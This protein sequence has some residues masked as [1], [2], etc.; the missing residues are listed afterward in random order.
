MVRHRLSKSALKWWDDWWDGRLIPSDS[1]IAMLTALK[2]KHAKPGKHVD[3]HGLHLLV[4]PSGGKFWL[5]RVQHRGQRR[6]FGLGCADDVSLEEARLAAQ[7]LRRQVKRGETPQVQVV[8]PPLEPRKKVPSFEKVTRDCYDALKD[9]WNDKRKRNWLAGFEQNI[10][11]AIGSKP[12]DKVDVAV[13]RDALAPVWLKIPDTARRILQRTQAVLDF[14]FL[15]GWIPAE[16]SLRTVR[17]GL[18]KHTDRSNHYAAMPYDDAAALAQKLAAAESSVG[19]DALRF[20]IL[21]ASRSGETRGATWT[22]IDLQKKVWSIPA[23]RMKAREP[24]QVPLTPQAMNILERR[25]KLR[26]DSSEYVF[27]N[28]GKKPLTDMAVSKALKGAGV[29]GFTVHGFRSTFTDWAAEK[30]DFPKEVADKALAH[31]I[32]DPVEAAYRRTDFFEKRRSLMT[33]WADFLDGGAASP[34]NDAEAGELVAVRA[35]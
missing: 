16:V 29:D 3:H 31:K 25:L 23:E 17:K 14:A 27:T 22:E 4:R 15:N 26:T 24:H 20:L 28:D 11:D 6:E 5:V 9:G 13:V 12:I 21:T 19:R 18:P 10:F 8:E 32:P 2:I 7:T 35:G 33:Q 34:A 1:T 30:T